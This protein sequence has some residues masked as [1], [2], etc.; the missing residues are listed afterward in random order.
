MWNNSDEMWRGFKKKEESV[1]D[2]EAE[3]RDRI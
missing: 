2:G 3:N 1:M